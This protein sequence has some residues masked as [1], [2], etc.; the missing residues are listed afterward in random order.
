MTLKE[1]IFPTLL[2]KQVCVRISVN[3]TFSAVKRNTGAI[4][5]SVKEPA[6]NTKLW[7]EKCISL[8]LIS[9]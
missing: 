4:Y 8:K 5:R 9:Q 3:Y 2:K 6:P 7:N 1:I